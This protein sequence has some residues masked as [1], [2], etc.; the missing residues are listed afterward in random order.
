MQALTIFSIPFCNN[1]T[2]ELLFFT[3][4]FWSI[5]AHFWAPGKRII[6]QQLNTQW[7]NRVGLRHHHIRTHIFRYRNW[8]IL[9]ILKYLNAIFNILHPF[10]NWLD[11]IWKLHEGERGQIS[12]NC[13]YLHQMEIDKQAYHYLTYKDFKL[14]ATKWR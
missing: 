4:L 3:E 8:A 14:Q 9:L 1:K 11:H 13:T 12:N 2:I 6:R 5:G 7:K 10:L